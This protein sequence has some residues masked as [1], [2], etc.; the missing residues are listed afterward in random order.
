MLFRS[1]AG[2]N[3]RDDD[4][5]GLIDEDAYGTI[6]TEPC[7]RNGN[8]GIR[9]CWDV[10]SGTTNPQP[11]ECHCA[12]GTSIQAC[13]TVE[14]D[15]ACAA[16]VTCIPPPPLCAEGGS[17]VTCGLAACTVA[18]VT[19]AVV[20]TD[21]FG[22]PL[23]FP[24]AASGEEWF[25]STLGARGGALADPRILF[26]SS[27][28]QAM[29]AG[30]GGTWSIQGSNVR[31]LVGPSPGVREVNGTY[32]ASTGQPNQPG[33]ADLSR[34]SL[35]QA[36]HMQ[37]ARDWRNVEMTGYLRV[38]Q[39]AAAPSVE[40][41]VTFY[42]RG[43]KHRSLSGHGVDCEGSA[44]KARLRLNG[45]L[46]FQKELRHNAYA[47]P[48]DAGTVSG[49]GAGWFGFKFVVRN[50]DDAVEMRAYLQP[51]AS[52]DWCQLAT[53]TDTDSWTIPSTDCGE[54]QGAQLITWGGPYA[55]FR[56]DEVERME[57]RALSV[58]E[59]D[60]AAMPLSVFPSCAP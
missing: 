47:A 22:I 29:E 26:G 5:D 39:L 9:S 60:P 11:G 13:G 31:L 25:L 35:R 52:G 4:G 2:C 41:A 8:V 51:G 6:Q 46:H 17:G 12:A 38:A 37:T 30:G 20:K 53:L 23:V 32:D 58:R 36:G 43:G 34:A 42:A 10:T 19:T 1:E 7:V 56:W 48:V 3:L 44:Y 49:P 24:T 40:P 15:E 55:T 59:I 16:E 57:V 14:L 54:I 18:D 27:G 28:V 50:V 21:P 45:D 33:G